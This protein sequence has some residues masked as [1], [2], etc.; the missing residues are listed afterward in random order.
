MI[1]A[2]DTLNRKYFQNYTLLGLGLAPIFSEAVK[3]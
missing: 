1:I 2:T 3:D